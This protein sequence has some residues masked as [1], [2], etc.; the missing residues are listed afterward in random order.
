MLD[1]IGRLRLPR[2]S[3]GLTPLAV[4]RKRAYTVEDMDENVY[5]DLAS[6]SASVPLGAGRDDLIDPAV[7]AIREIGNEDSHA[8]VSELT[9]ELAERLLDIAP[10]SLTHF[11]IALNGTEAIEIAV[12]M[13]RRSTGRPVVIGFMGGYHGESTITAA[14]GSGA[15][16]DQPRA[17]GPRARLRARPVPARVQTPFREPR[18]GRERRLDRRLHQR[19]PAVPRRRPGEVA[20]VLI[21][22]VLG[23]GGCVRRPDAFWPA[24]T[25]LCGEHG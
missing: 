14:L 23:S 13:M 8:L 21:E 24:L 19:P 25:E 10:A 2:P 3:E 1:R 12:K 9:A 5:L 18:P 22:P 16:G 4:A 17:A 6:A 15:R 7:A 20:G 11:D